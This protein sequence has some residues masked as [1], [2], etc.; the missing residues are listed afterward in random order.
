MHSV[1]S[2][3]AAALLLA[4]AL[5]VVVAA[6]ASATSGRISLESLRPQKALEAF[7]EVF[8]LT[9]GSADFGFGKL[10]VYTDFQLVNSK[11]GAG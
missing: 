10:R 1:G 4:A 5:F 9:R 6:A 11:G 7:L 3:L 8:L 2:H